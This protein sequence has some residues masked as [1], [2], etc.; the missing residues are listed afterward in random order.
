[1][2]LGPKR[3]SG[4]LLLGPKHVSE[5]MLLGSRSKM[6][7]WKDVTRSKS[8]QWKL[9]TQS[10]N[11]RVTSFHCHV[12]DRVPSNI[13]SLTRFGPSNNF[14]M[15]RFGPS[16]QFPLTRF[17]PSNMFS[18]KTITRNLDNKLKLKVKS[19]SVELETMFFVILSLCFMIY[20]KIVR[21]ETIPLT[22]LPVTS[23]SSVWILGIYVS[24]ISWGVHCCVHSWLLSNRDW[25]Q[26][27]Y[28]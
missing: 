7:Q 1:M 25:V 26:L 16:N 24:N 2:L 18:L 11:D 27:L 3:V 21:A 22:G 5:K 23:I 20:V 15:T 10:K 19:S 13:F 17:G 8:C 9:V 6:C 28:T 4:K 14:L 12:L